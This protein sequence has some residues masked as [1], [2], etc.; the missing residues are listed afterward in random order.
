MLK[1]AEDFWKKYD[2]LNCYEPDYQC[3]QIIHT[4][5]Y[6]NEKKLGEI[7]SAVF[8]QVTPQYKVSVYG[9]TLKVDYRILYEDKEIFVEF[10][11]YRH[12]TNS[13]TIERDEILELHCSVNDIILI[14]IPYWIQLN[15]YTFEQF[16]GEEIFE[17][18][19]KNKKIALTTSYP[20]GFI[21]EL[22]HD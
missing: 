15:S 18:V 22:T 16:F 21:N 20:S 4:D 12:Y 1:E 10:N 9:Q 5:E 14:S 3:D 7:L 8:E 2:H 17:K 19:L 6:L 11:G 13:K